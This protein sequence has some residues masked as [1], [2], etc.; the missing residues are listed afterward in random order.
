MFYSGDVYIEQSLGNIVKKAVGF[1]Q[2]TS[3]LQEE[4][5]A[6][7]L[8]L[9]FPLARRRLTVSLALSDGSRAQT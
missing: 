3:Q 7:P 9:W 5:L 1:H 6:S 8:G 4:G 2:Q